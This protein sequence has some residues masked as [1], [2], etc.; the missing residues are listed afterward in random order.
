[1]EYFSTNSFSLE[2]K[3]LKND[4][5]PIFWDGVTAFMPM[6]SSFESFLK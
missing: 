4:R 2:K 1:M 6:G 5:K 3:S